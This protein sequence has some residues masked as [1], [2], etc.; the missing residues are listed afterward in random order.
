MSAGQF[1]LSK[2]E[3]DNGDIVPIRVQPETLA[4][5]DGM[6]ANAA[7][8]AA[9]SAG[10]PSA[11]VSAGRRSLGINARKVSLRFTAAPPDGYA[12]NG[13]LSVPVLKVDTF[14]AY[15]KGASVTYLEKA[16]VVVGRSPETIN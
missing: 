4:L 5:T 10:F 9:V 14:A 3:T 7:P 15:T 11:Q 2:Y 16:A 8:T 6:K 1:V 12:P 13:I